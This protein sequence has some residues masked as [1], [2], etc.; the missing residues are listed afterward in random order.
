MLVTFF[1][2][3]DYKVLSRYKCVTVLFY[4]IHCVCSSAVYTVCIYSYV[5]LYS[6]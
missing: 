5:L 4:V 2:V 6:I 1:V 3:V